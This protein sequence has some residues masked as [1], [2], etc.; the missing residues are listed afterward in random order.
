MGEILVSLMSAAWPSK[1][2]LSD[3]SSLAAQTRPES[4]P[5]AA[6]ALLQTKLWPHRLLRSIKGVWTRFA[7]LS[8]ASGRNNELKRRDN[9]G[10]RA[11]QAQ[12]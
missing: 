4:I 1:F 8:F 5:V 11:Q 6:L 7:S 9:S 12:R 3:S 10:A 2:Y